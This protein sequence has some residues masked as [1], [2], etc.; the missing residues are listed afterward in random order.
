MAKITHI[1][2]TF[3][4]D[5]PDGGI[6]EVIHQLGLISIK[7]GYDIEV[8]SLSKNPGV[9]DYDGIKCISYK[10]N[11]SFSSMPISV[12]LMRNFSKIIKDTD[13]IHLHYPFPFTE[14]L[15]LFCKTKK[16]IVITFHAPI[17]G[18]HILMACYTYFAKRL[19][20][21]ANVIIPTSPNLA[22]TEHLFDV[23]REKINPIGLWISDKRFKNQSVHADF[24][25]QVEGYNSFALFVGV[26]RSYKGLHYL[27]DAAK[28]VSH[29]IIVVGRGPLYNELKQR[30]EDE[31][32]LNVHLLGFQSNEYVAYLFEKCTFVVL[33]SI[34]RGECFG[35]VLLEACHYGKPMISTE[36]GTGTSWVNTNKTGFVI[37]PRDAIILADKMNALFRNSELCVTLGAFAKQRAEQM[38]SAAACGNAYLDIYDK[39]LNK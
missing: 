35:M 5:E 38:F 13:I 15:T 32:I 3:Y 10:T 4:P 39:L 1:F 36:L 31:K 8:V 19:F 30:I 21:K 24:A 23:C 12:D 16:P 7:R 29:D 9:F 2:K 33:P 28:R 37:P 26:L 34:T 6:Q 17:E 14:L 25:K 20:K 22:S 27:L 11:I 18:R